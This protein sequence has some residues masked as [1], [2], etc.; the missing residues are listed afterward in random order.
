MDKQNVICTYTWNILVTKMNEVL[1]YAMTLVKLENVM[2]SKISQLQNC[3]IP[4]I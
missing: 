3:I 2:V 4:L 1:I